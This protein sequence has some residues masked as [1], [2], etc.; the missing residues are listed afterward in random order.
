MKFFE[1]HVRDTKKETSDSYSFLFDI[2]EGYTWKAGQHAVWRFVCFA[3][4]DEE[5]QARVFTIAS[6]PQDGFL[7]LTTRIG[8]KHSPLKEALLTRIQKGDTVKISAPMGKFAFHEEKKWSLAVAGGI[9]ITPI[10]ALLRE[11][12]EENREDHQV[13]LYY[14]DERNEFCYEDL[15]AALTKLPNIHIEKLSDSDLCAEK[16]KTF[17]KEHGD[18]AEYLIAGSPGMNKFYEKLL[19]EA[20]IEKKDIVTDVF[21]GY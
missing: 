8:E 2:P 6:A 20:D 17:A 19:T 16:V 3:D 21:L 1:T 11:Y 7:M 18:Q 12:L 14:A 10:R 9:G 5:E 4:L 15:W 13:V